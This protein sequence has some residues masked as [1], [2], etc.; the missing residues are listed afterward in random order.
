MCNA[1]RSSSKAPNP[2]AGLAK[3]FALVEVLVGALVLA[4]GSLTFAAG[5]TLAVRGHH[6]SASRQLAVNAAADIGELLRVAAP[7]QRLAVVARWQARVSSR[8]PP[9]AAPLTASVEPVTATAARIPAWQAQLQWQDGIA[10]APLRLTARFG[11]S[12]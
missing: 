10:A 8:W 3:G 6:A 7:E 1:D 2:A 4:F 5:L 9:A 12:P 11:I